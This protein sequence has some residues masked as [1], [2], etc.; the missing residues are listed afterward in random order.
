MNTFRLLK[1]PH[2][3]VCYV[4]NLIDTVH[5]NNRNIPLQLLNKKAFLFSRQLLLNT[6]PFMY[7][8]KYT[9]DFKDLSG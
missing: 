7:S 6:V 1:V 8:R 5:Q 4:Q 2:L 9:Q 3:E